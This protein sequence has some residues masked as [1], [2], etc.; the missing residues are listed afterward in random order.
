MIV[1]CIDE[2]WV[3]SVIISALLVSTSIWNSENFADDDVISSFKVSNLL[4][5]TFI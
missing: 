2:I 1:Y 4:I 3:S 5:N